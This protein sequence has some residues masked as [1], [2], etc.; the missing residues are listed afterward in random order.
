MPSLIPPAIAQGSIAASPQPVL[1]A[2]GC[3][4]LSPLEPAD[5]PELAALSA[6]PAFQEWH[7]HRIDSEE[8]AREVAGNWARRWALQ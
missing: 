7:G 8:E 1:A 3:L 4:V 6:D 2:D 5:A